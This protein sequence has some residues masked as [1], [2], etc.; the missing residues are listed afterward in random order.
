MPRLGRHD[1]GADADF[2][3]RTVFWTNCIIHVPDKAST[4]CWQAA[5]VSLQAAP[6]SAT[7]SSRSCHLA[8]LYG[9]LRKQVVWRGHR[10]KLERIARGVFEEHCPLLAGSSLESDVRLD[11]K[12]HAIRAHLRTST[13]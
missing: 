6:Q 13:R 7:C 1:A 5:D 11:D 8:L 2:Q 12:E 3:T 10:F 4:D 9:I